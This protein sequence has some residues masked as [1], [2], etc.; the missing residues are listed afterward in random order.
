MRPLARKI[1]LTEGFV[2]L[3]VF[4]VSL[5][6]YLS[7]REARTRASHLRAEY[8]L[9]IAHESLLS[10]LR[11]IGRSRVYYFV[12]EQGAG[13]LTGAFRRSFH[14]SLERVAQGVEELARRA[15]SRA[16]LA[17]LVADLRTQLQEY[18]QAVAEQEV[19]RGLADEERFK[20]AAQVC[21]EARE[22]MSELART[23]KSE[24][25][26]IVS[27]E[28]DA[29]R[30]A[31]HRATLVALALSVM[32]GLV[33]SV[34]IFWL[35]RSIQRPVGDL[36]AATEALARG[37]FDRRIEV[38]NEDELGDLARAFNQMAARLQE[39]DELKSG[40]VSMVSHDLK[41]PLTSMKEAVDLLS[42]GVGGDLTPRQGRLLSIASKGMER[43]N[44]YVQGILDLFR[45]EAGHVRLVRELFQI[46]DVVQAQLDMAEVRCRESRITLEKDL[47]S[48]LPLVDGDRFRLGQ[49]VANLLDNGIKFTPPGGRIRVRTGVNAWKDDL[50]VYLEVSDTGMGISA[51]DQKHVFEK[52]FQAA[53]GRRVGHVRGAGLGLAI[54]RSLVEAHGGRIRL[55]SS[56]GRGTSFRVILPTAKR[57]AGE[58]ALAG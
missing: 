34:A 50:A 23:S 10:E 42:E 33:G 36:Q 3:M 12:E 16:D 18:R 19:A 26:E 15:G 57:M 37:E 45:F 49:V 27:G 7:L 5:F 28:I 22:K 30:Q 20:A 52:F 58:E 25:E 2:I 13:P 44:H 51:R 8:E 31:A 17:P 32:A 35:I 1:F 24:R 29:L 38:Q 54:V 21:Q 43:L 47:E 46:S 40:F 56:P 4:G 53:G 48:D 9:G 11:D 41:T 6:G 55:T 39:L 14:E